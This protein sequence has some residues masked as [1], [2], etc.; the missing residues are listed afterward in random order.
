MSEI[1]RKEQ[2]A[3]VKPDHK[4]IAGPVA[5]DFMKELKPL[6]SEGVT[7][8]VIDL[9]AVQ[10]IDSMGLSVLVAAHN[11]LQKID[12]QLEITNVS[13]NILKL[14]KEMRL[15]RHFLIS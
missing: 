3:V 6:L 5:Q 11:S 13:E 4:N 10:L 12:S 15:D 1:T 8:L 9:S 2:R 7:R 14:M